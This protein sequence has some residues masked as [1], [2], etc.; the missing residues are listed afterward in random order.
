MYSQTSIRQLPA[1][2][3]T[4]GDSST[5]P[6]MYLGS[7]MACTNPEVCWIM[8][9]I[10]GST[11]VISY[12]LWDARR[13][14]SWNGCWEVIWSNLLPQGGSLVVISFWRRFI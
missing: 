1:Q 13:P 6:E 2:S 12:I 3:E 11:L 10:L 4:G 9:V 14:Q 8:W 5:I 7:S